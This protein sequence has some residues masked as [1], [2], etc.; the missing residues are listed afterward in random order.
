KP[1][2]TNALLSIECSELPVPR[3]GEQVLVR[4]TL[5]LRSSAFL[6][7]PF[8]GVAS[9]TVFTTFDAPI[10]LELPNN[11]TILSP[12]AAARLGNDSANNPLQTS[13]PSPAKITPNNTTEP[14]PP[15]TRPQ[16]RST[17]VAIVDVNDWSLVRRFSEEYTPLPQRTPALEMAEQ[18]CENTVLIR[19]AISNHK[20]L[21]RQWITQAERPNECETVAQYYSALTALRRIAKLYAV[22]RIAK[23]QPDS[24]L[25]LFAIQAPSKADALSPQWLHTSLAEPLRIFSPD[26]LRQIPT[27]VF[28]QI[29]SVGTNVAVRGSM[30]HLDSSLKTVAQYLHRILPGYIANSSQFLVGAILRGA[31]NEISGVRITKE[32]SAETLG[33]EVVMIAADSLLVRRFAEVFTPGLPRTPALERAEA[34]CDIT[35]NIVSRIQLRQSIPADWIDK[36]TS[37]ADCETVK[38]FYTALESSRRI[39]SVYILLDKNTLKRGRISVLG[40]IAYENK[41]TFSDSKFPQLSLDMEDLRRFKTKEL[42]K[43]D[44]AGTLVSVKGSMDSTPFEYC[45]EYCQYYAEQIFKQGI[46]PTAL[47]AFAVRNNGRGSIRRVIKIQPFRTK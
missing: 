12:V 30:T 8:N 44:S 6:R 27:Q 23:G 14:L 19:S 41:N 2:G 32:F 20:P 36:S 18:Y 3:K 35:T 22:C 42:E 34:E 16:M 39:K 43:D 33:E 38:N 46:P 29:D 7:N 37:P 9:K 40:T 28:V 24:L 26:D 47:T 5:A 1:Y 11:P 4:G 10:T 31:K 15:R 17:D 21:E 45:A 25:A 13:S